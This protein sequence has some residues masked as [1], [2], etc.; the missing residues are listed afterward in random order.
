[1]ADFGD[2]IKGMRADPS[3]RYTREA[4]GP[5]IF[6]QHIP[7]SDVALEDWFPMA[8]LFDF[9]ASQAE[10]I[11]LT[12]RIVRCT[13]GRKGVDPYWMPSQADMLA[14]DWQEVSL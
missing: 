3:K 11:H 14:D 8:A 1:M 12:A 4:W 5:G 10:T 2:V 13:P 7:G 6:I 9:G